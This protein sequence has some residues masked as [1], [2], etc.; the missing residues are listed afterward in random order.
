MDADFSHPPSYLKRIIFEK[1]KNDFDVIVFSRFLKLSE[2]YYDKEKS[3]PVLIDYLS[4]IL[5]KI[6]SRMLFKS[7]TDYTSGYICIK[8]NIFKD[9]RLSGY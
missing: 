8:K 6:C 3:K 5:N 4:I 7:F 1:E 2:R 9:Y